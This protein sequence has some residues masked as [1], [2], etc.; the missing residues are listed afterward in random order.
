MNILPF[1]V[2]RSPYRSLSQGR[3]FPWARWHGQCGFKPL[4]AI[5]P[6]ISA[7]RRSWL[8]ISG[9]V[10]SA[11][12]AI[13]WLSPWYL[14]RSLNSNWALLAAL[15]LYSGIKGS[16]VRCQLLRLEWCRGCT[17]YYYIRSPV[18]SPALHGDVVLMTG[19]WLCVN[20]THL[21]D[22]LYQPSTWR[23]ASS[24]YKLGCVGASGNAQFM[25]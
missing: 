24:W 21:R 20:V 13:L 4:V 16:M 22:P 10:I 6:S 11:S 17:L 18:H 15:C 19:P 1:R 8:A 9:H 3:D 7:Y 5:Y 14:E 2:S 12:Q 23:G 25:V